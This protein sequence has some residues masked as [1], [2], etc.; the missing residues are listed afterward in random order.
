MGRS[1]FSGPSVSCRHIFEEVDAMA[2]PILGIVIFLGSVLLGSSPVVAE[3]MELLVPAYFYP[4]ENSPWD[5][6]AMAAASVPITA[7]L[8]PNSGPGSSVD[9][10]YVAVVNSLRAAGG[11][12]I[13][14]VATS[15]GSKSA[16]T[17]KSQIDK[18]IDFYAI[19]GI[20][21]DEMST[22]SLKLSYYGDLYDY[23]KAKNG[24][25]EVVGNPGTNTLESYLTTPTADV[26]VT[27]E[28]S[29]TAY[30]SFAPDVWSDGYDASH[31]AHIVHTT[32]SGDLQTVL[33][34]AA[35]RNAGLIFVTDDVMSN[36]YDTL[37]A[38]WNQEVSAVAAMA[39]P[40]PSALVL[41]G[42]GALAL[43]LGRRIRRKPPG[44]CSG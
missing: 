42:M 8:N 24:A 12:V 7:I 40:E 22:S 41:A 28:D 25:Y 6:L 11:R 10:N 17:V 18:Y 36:P 15:Y 33:D 31:F 19:D 37:P 21:L 34:L 2:K 35:A 5:D 14:Y 44:I 3:T 16:T 1:V 38:Y 20:F 39:A 4:V 26:L 13:G 23:I 30:S 32:S 9:P 29:R 27:F 43:I